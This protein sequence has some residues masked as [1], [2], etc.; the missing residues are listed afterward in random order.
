MKIAL[1]KK[2]RLNGKFNFKSRD[3]RFELDDVDDAPRV[4]LKHGRPR[5]FRAVANGGREWM[6]W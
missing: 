6:S 3:W 2:N 4:P 5:K 1:A